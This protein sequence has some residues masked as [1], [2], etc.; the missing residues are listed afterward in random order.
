[1]NGEDMNQNRGI[2]YRQ[3]FAIQAP[4]LQF[5]VHVHRSWLTAKA[6]IHLLFTLMGVKEA[7]L[8]RK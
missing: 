6:I 1:V 5:T 8:N 2:K 7:N 4:S 3:P